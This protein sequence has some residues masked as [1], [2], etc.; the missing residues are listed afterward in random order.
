LASCNE[1]AENATIVKE[2]DET[3]YYSSRTL[4]DSRMFVTHPETCLRVAAARGFP[5]HDPESP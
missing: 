5:V 3:R 4:S 1:T 2:G